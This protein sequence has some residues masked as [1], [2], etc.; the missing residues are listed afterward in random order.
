MSLQGC[1]SQ[2]GWEGLEFIRNRLP[3]RSEIIAVLGV[4]VFACFSWTILRF[5]NKFSSFLLYL[6]VAEIAEIFAFMMAFALLESLVVTGILV[7]LSGILPPGWLRAGF[8]VKGLVVIF[9]YGSASLILQ[10]TIPDQ[11]PSLI[12]LG[13]G[14]L[15]PLG[16]IIALLLF[17]GSR[18]R[19]RGI[20]LNFQ[21]RLTIMM[22]IYIPLGVLC[23]MIVLF[24]NVL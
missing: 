11:F 2:K 12:W 16:L 6:T 20:L 14:T 10:K 17:I 7:V 1:N 23:L 19:I 13:L 15:V 8:S 3:Y 21:D 4:A 5:F 22:Y 9:I 24:R 18:P